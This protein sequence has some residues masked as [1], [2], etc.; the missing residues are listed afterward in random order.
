[1]F[2]FIKRLFSSKE[3]VPSKK[4]IEERIDYID[5]T[6]PTL[7]FN[8][9]K[10]NINT[11][12]VFFGK[13]NIITDIE[14]FYKVY[15]PNKK[16]VLFLDNYEDISFVIKACIDKLETPS[17]KSA[18]DEFNFIGIFGISSVKVMYNCD[19][20]NKVKIDYAILDLTLEELLKYKNR[21]VTIDGVDV[22]INIKNKYKDC[23][24]MFLTS[25]T[26]STKVPTLR[27]FYKKYEFY[28]GKHINK[29]LSD[30]YIAKNKV[31]KDNLLS[32]I[33]FDK[34]NKN[35]V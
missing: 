28:I 29:I 3:I 30:V 32:K 12:F 5:F 14:E 8:Y 35:V 23:I 18:K 26:L 31:L 16:T 15:D 1:M 24:V 21:P 7:D 4:E 13:E 25:H 19:I 20:L 22:G 34:G 11:K 9:K 27:K 17:G 33:F 6:N 2:G 10:T